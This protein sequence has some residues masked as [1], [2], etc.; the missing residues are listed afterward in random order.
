VSSSRVPQSERLGEPDS[1]W[2]FNRHASRRRRLKLMTRR[3]CSP[4]RTIATVVDVLTQVSF[5]IHTYA[6]SESMN[7]EVFYNADGEMLVVPEVANTL[8]WMGATILNNARIGR[9]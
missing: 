3:V 8:I 5:A 1:T 6:V 4:I 7:T 2:H 9:N